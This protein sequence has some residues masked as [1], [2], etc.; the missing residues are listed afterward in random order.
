M[1]YSQPQALSGLTVS[2]GDL[3]HRS[4][5]VDGEPPSHAFVI[6]LKSR[7]VPLTLRAMSSGI[8]KPKKGEDPDELIPEHS[9]EV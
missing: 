9:V 4:R 8:G 3:M 2:P 6:A 5:V 1:L 7:T